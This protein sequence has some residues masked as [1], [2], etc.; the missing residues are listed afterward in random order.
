M[1]LYNNIHTYTL[2]DRCNNTAVAFEHTHIEDCI[3]FL[4]LHDDGEADEEKDEDIGDLDDLLREEREM[5]KKVGSQY[6]L[7][8]RYI[9]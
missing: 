5:E 9:S 6:Q 2:L 1:H 3:C 8:Q 7:M 4:S